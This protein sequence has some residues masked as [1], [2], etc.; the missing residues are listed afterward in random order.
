[1]KSNIPI[2]SKTSIASRPKTIA[3]N[4][5]E[6]PKKY[7]QKWSREEFFINFYIKDK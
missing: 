4:H 7:P 3:V 5:Y 2:Y 1:M 6:Y